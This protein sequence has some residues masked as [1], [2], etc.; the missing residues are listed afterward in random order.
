MVMMYPSYAFSKNNRPTSAKR[1]IFLKDSREVI[2]E[3]RFVYGYVLSDDGT[4]VHCW[5]NLDCLRAVNVRT[6]VATSSKLDDQAIGQAV[7]SPVPGIYPNPVQDVLRIQPPAGRWADEIRLE[8]YTSQG[9]SMLSLLWTRGREGVDVSA[10]KAGTYVLRWVGPHRTE[11]VKF[12][13]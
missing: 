4:R 2:S 1:D 8:I 6:R 10:L 9:Q 3:V 7:P 11:Q 13:K 5:A 12:I